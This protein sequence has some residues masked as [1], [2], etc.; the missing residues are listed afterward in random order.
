MLRDN[1]AV[2]RIDFS[3]RVSLIVY[4]LFVVRGK[5]PA[6]T[7]KAHFCLCFVYL[8]F[9]QNLWK[10]I[11]VSLQIRTLPRSYCTSPAI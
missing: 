6:Q 9:F 8:G 7:I 3:S 2:I 11:I 10:Q 4:K 1:P 5:A